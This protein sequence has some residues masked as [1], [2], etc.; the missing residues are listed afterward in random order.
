MYTEVGKFFYEKFDVL[1]PWILKVQCFLEN[2]DFQILPL[3]DPK[4]P[5]FQ[6]FYIRRRIRHSDQ[7]ALNLLLDSRTKD[8]KLFFLLEKKFP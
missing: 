7:Q 8:I 3:E 5:F 6:K 4:G 1:C 2:L